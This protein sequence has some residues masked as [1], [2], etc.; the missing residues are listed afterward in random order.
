MGGAGFGV[1]GSGG[2]A[3]GAEQLQGGGDIRGNT[4]Y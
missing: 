2:G 3:F 4:E 1:H